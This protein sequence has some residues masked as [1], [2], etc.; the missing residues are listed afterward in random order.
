MAVVLKDFRL[1]TAC[2]A[3]NGYFLQAIA[4]S[5]GYPVEEFAE[6]AF[7]AKEMPVFGQGCV[8]FLQSEISNVQRHGW[9]PEEILAGLASVLPKNVFLYVA[10]SPEPLAVRMGGSSCRAA[11]SGTWRP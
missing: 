2:S 11:R 9:K 1:N 6:A 3:G 5:F 4:K 8:L 7:S 10:K